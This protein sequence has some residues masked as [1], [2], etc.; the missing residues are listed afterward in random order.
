MVASQS[1]SSSTS[2]SS[3]WWSEMTTYHWW[4]LGVATLGWL[5]DSMD[6]RLFVLARTPALHKLLARG[7]G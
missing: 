5:F 1:S 7:C 6:Q 4:V 3:P 2:D